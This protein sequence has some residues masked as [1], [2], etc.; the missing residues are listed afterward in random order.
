MPETDALLIAPYSDPEIRAL[1]LE[2]PE[3]FK[4]GV[5]LENIEIMYR[6]WIMGEPAAKIASDLQMTPGALYKRIHDIKKRIRKVVDCDDDPGL[7]LRLIKEI[8]KPL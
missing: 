8:R 3:R 2:L 4:R 5:S 6:F 1:Y 7:I